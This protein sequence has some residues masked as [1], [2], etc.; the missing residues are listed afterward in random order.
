MKIKLPQLP[1]KTVF[2]KTDPAFLEKRRIA[3]QNFLQ[4]V[5]NEGEL[6]QEPS[7]CC[8]HFPKGDQLT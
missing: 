3:L 1:A 5:V 8:A 2:A 7:T 6:L 4:A